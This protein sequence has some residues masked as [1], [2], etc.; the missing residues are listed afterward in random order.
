MWDFILPL[1]V[2]QVEG[3]GKNSEFLDHSIHTPKE[4]FENGKLFGNPNRYIVCALNVLN[5]VRVC[6]MYR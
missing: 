5:I 6:T 4:S 2:S 1:D 3:Q